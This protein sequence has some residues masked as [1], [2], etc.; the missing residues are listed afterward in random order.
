MEII[1]NKSIDDSSLP[2]LSDGSSSPVEELNNLDEIGD[3]N[4]LSIDPGDH[5]EQ[6]VTNIMNDL[7]TVTPPS[8]HSQSHVH[9]SHEENKPFHSATSPDLTSS[10]APTNNISITPTHSDPPEDEAA[11][12]AAAQPT[13]VTSSPV[14][15]LPPAVSLATL[16]A[17]AST[18][19]MPNLSDT[20]SVAPASLTLVDEGEAG[21]STVDTVDERLAP[22]TLL[23]TEHATD[24]NNGHLCPPVPP[25]TLSALSAP[26]S[27]TLVSNPSSIADDTPPPPP[28]V[29]DTSPPPS[30]SDQCE[31]ALLTVGTSSEAQVA[32]M[33]LP[34]T[35]DVALPPTTAIHATSP[36]PHPS[37]TPDTTSAAP[38]IAGQGVA[39]S[40][41]I[42]PS[43][44]TQASPANSSSIGHTLDN[45]DKSLP[46]TV[47]PTIAIPGENSPI[48][49]LPDPPATSNSSSAHPSLSDEGE[50]V[51]HT[52]GPSD[53]DQLASVTSTPTGHIVDRDN[54]SSPLADPSATLSDIPAVTSSAPP[55]NPLA[56][57]DPAH[58]VLADQGEKDAIETAADSES[59]SMTASALNQPRVVAEDVHSSTYPPSS[60]VEEREAVMSS[61]ISS[62]VPGPPVV[63]NGAAVSAAKLNSD[64]Q[65]EPTDLKDT[66]FTLHEQPR[67]FKVEEDEKEALE[68]EVP[69]IS[70]DLQAPDRR[71]HSRARLDSLEDRNNLDTDSEMQLSFSES[72]KESDTEDYPGRRPTRKRQRRYRRSSSSI[73]SSEDE[74]GPFVER[75]NDLSI[76]SSPEPE[77]P[78][79]GGGF[80]VSMSVGEGVVK[81]FKEQSKF[82]DLS[83]QIPPPDIPQLQKLDVSTT[84]DLNEHTDKYKGR[85]FY[86]R[87]AI[88]VDSTPTLSDQIESRKVGLLNED[89]G[90]GGF[91]TQLG[92]VSPSMGART[93]MSELHDTRQH[94]PPLS[95]QEMYTKEQLLRPEITATKGEPYQS[96]SDPGLSSQPVYSGLMP[97][98]EQE[99]MRTE[100]TSQVTRTS[101]PLL[102]STSSSSD[103]LQLPVR[104]SFSSH[105]PSIAP[106][107]D[108]VDHL[109]KLPP[110][111][112]SAPSTGL[113]SMLD[114][115]PP[116]FT[117]YAAPPP[118][119]RAHVLEQR[120]DP[121]YSISVVEDM[122]VGDTAG[123]EERETA[124]DVEEKD[125]NAGT[126]MEGH[127][128]L[129][130]MQNSLYSHQSFNGGST[131]S[132]SHFTYVP[133]MVCIPLLAFSYKLVLSHSLLRVCY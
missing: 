124:M 12:T 24:G 47:Q 72:E 78:N 18:T 51:P 77:L 10:V 120:S 110:V 64:T 86:E 1:D 75:R 112:S 11:P 67:S 53:E 9:A 43:I 123:H 74:R 36:L 22:V 50:T 57:T 69:V 7:N 91:Q 109:P 76:V 104:K 71:Y 122:D 99:P 97:S 131:G 106:S 54:R 32:S 45:D 14:E 129:G 23:S 21:L 132:T 98:S 95:E 113:H 96:L 116:P 70:S 55:S 28:I 17:P 58:S 65:E 30:L 83:S 79:D 27:S 56:S 88:R 63:H 84:D 121:V 34:Y 68:Y 41:T 20:F 117:H 90:H 37:A 31:A 107:L 52:G 101:D 73:S 127:T 80:G 125:S 66:K 8:S 85:N 38:I 128:E 13:P 46:P 35:D 26:A 114:Q 60:T 39:A 89:E 81:K 33:T 19:P 29:D 2:P 25:A 4:G 61:E 40:H 16:S 111:S 44:E 49:P 87:S 119:F 126:G 103:Q 82:N 108:R 5:S 118:I 130:L 62:S 92:S 15:P 102:E 115:P 42:G 93:L 3:D 59:A 6:A 133:S 48:T 94:K 105:P 100:P